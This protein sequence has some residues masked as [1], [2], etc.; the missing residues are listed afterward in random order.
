[1]DWGVVYMVVLCFSCY[2][3]FN[4]DHTFYVTSSCVL[5]DLFLTLLCDHT[6]CKSHVL[7][8]DV[9]SS[10]VPSDLFLPLLCCPIFC[11]SHVLPFDVTSS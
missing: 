7:P 1:M 3:V 2:L 4:T 8:F 6:L 10:C 11:K 5:S 9:T